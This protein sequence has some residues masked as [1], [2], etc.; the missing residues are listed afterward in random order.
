MLVSYLELAEQITALDDRIRF[1]GVS[2]KLGKII[3]SSYRKG[4]TPLLNGE[5]TEKSIPQTVLRGSIQTE[6]E[7][8]LGKTL[9]S[10]TVYERIKRVIIPLYDIYSNSVAV[11]LVSF[12]IEVANADIDS[13][14]INRIM[15][16]IRGNDDRQREFCTR[17][18]KK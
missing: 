18:I 15:P 4:L 2:N 13:I 6:L 3:A 10:I 8:K 5:E 9:Y 7:K 1:A 11:L 17:F 14:I 12:D 16:L